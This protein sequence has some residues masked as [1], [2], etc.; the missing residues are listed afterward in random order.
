VEWVLVYE[1]N[2]APRLRAGSDSYTRR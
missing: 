1:E 2:G